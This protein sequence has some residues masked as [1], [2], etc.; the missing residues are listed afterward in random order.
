MKS[1]II[2]DVHLKNKDQFDITPNA[3]NIYK[4]DVLSKII[5]KESPD[6]IFFAGDLFDTK[7]PPEEFRILFFELTNKYPKKLFVVIAGNHDNKGN[8]PVGTSESLVSKNV[9]VVPCNEVLRLGSD[10]VC[11]GYTRNEKIYESL[12]SGLFL[13]G[14]GDRPQANLSFFKGIFF[15]HIHKHYVSGNF[16]SVSSLFKQSW[17]EENELNGYYVIDNEEYKYIEVQDLKL[18]TID[19][20]PESFNTVLN[21]YDFIRVKMEIQPQDINSFK[22]IDKVFTEF[23]IKKIEK[24]I[25]SVNVSYQQEIQKLFQELK[26]NKSQIMFGKEILEKVKE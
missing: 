13:I 12:D 20:I 9:M 3:R 22:K 2:A 17:A 10:F 24:K 5:E 25:D 15:G 14:H 23:E 7:T 1:I 11:V 6:N 4:I 16:H 21:K 19:Y 26:L 18:K 8:Y